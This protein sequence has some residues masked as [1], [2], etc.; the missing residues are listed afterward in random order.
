[1]SVT[2]ADWD[3]GVYIVAGV[4]LLSLQSWLI[5]VLLANR[6]QRRRAQATLA[7]ELRFETL[8]S[9]ILAGQLTRRA[10]AAAAGIHDALA[11]IGEHLD[12]D[13]VALAERD[14]DNDR[15][16]VVHVWVRPGISGIPQSIGWSAFPWM[17]SEM[18]AGRPIRVSPQHP[19][20]PHASVDRQGMARYNSRSVLGVPLIVEDKVVGLFTCAT[21]R[22]ER[23]WPDALLD[24]MRLLADVFASELARRRAEVAARETTERFERQRQELTHALRV[25]TLGELGASLAHEINQPLAAILLN[26]RTLTGLLAPRD[27][28]PT[29][30][31]EVLSDIAAD[32]RR[33]GEI[34]ARL[35]AL[36]RKEQIVESGLDLDVLI[37]EVVALLRQDFVRRGITVHRFRA[38][39]SPTVKGDRIQLQQVFLNLLMNASEALEANAP[40]Q[41]DVIVSTGRAAPGL[42][43]VAVRD[44]GP[45]AAGVD[46]EQIFQ[47][48][49]TTKST[50]LGMGLA[51]SRS[52]A[53]SHGGRIYAR[54]NPDHG[55]TV[56]V[57]LPAEPPRV[58]GEA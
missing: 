11:R 55:L 21:V 3:L 20:P 22:G 18:A 33:A 43:E 17:A 37:D 46:T 25:N 15:V 6:A 42:L 44:N 16:D 2:S 39:G 45:G 36:S 32:A 10:A 1:M 23:E 47:R 24:R 8:I 57:E 53:T 51:I 40:G 14:A 30:V 34:I 41:R 9:D 27:K 52:I 13:R 35:R 38:V 28:G 26:A 29:A 56:Y 7:A 12:V 49:V 54:V 50:G 4:V 19:L 48:F 31:G 58:S 5:V